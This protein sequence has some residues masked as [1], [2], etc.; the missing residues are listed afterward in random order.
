MRLVVFAMFCGT[1][2]L[3]APAAGGD[4]PKKLGHHVVRVT[5]P[6]ARGAVEVAVAINSTNPDHIVA[7][8]NQA[9]PEDSS[10]VH[11]YVSND[12]GLT[13][14][15]VAGPNPDRRHQGDAAVAFG[16]DGVVHRT[17]LALS[18]VRG[19]RT[20]FAATG[21]HT[22][23]SKDGL[24]WADPAPIVDH[25]N[26][27]EPLEDKPWLDI[28]HGEK[29]PQR[30][31]IYM[32]WTRFDV[33][34]SKDPA[35]KSHVYFSRSKDGGKSFSKMRRISEKPGDCTDSGGTV[36]AAM[37]AV[38]TKGEVF[39]TWAGPEGIVFKKSLDGS[40]KFSEEK[41]LTATPGGWDIPIAGLAR[42]NGLP[43]I[44]VDRSPGEHSGSVY[45]N[46][47]DK[48][49]GDPDVLCMSSRDAGDTWSEPVRVNDDPKGNGKD[50]FFTWMAVDPRDGSI[51]IIF[52]DRRNLKDTETALTLARSTDG[53]QTFVNH[54]VAQEPFPC[55]KDFFFGDYIGVAAFNGR[56][57][58]L[59]S[60]FTGRRSVAISAALF[61]FKPGTQE[62][63][64][65]E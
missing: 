65:G 62:L 42:S 41:V 19:N 4:P 26:S 36:M 7:A 17:Y 50:Q 29:S 8:S 33:Y 40:V 6:D 61:R 15:D 12:G 49:N 52:Y 45:V 2:A 38:G 18:G 1:A 35:H 14:K 11:M 20:P 28:D 51:N 27:T 48:R 22:S 57:V 30:G 56:V 21:I 39:V 43:V 47:I 16:P 10:A 60:H 31:T 3:I 44:G 64:G 53:G 46:W 13:W 63:V 9:R 34:G 23:S 54:K 37:P 32:S 59:Y 24:T 55:H 5:G 58:A 25:I